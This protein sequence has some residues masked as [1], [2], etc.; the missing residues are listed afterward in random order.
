[1]TTGDA[2]NQH[3]LTDDQL[4]MLL[5]MTDDKLLNHIQAIVDPTTLQAIMDLTAATVGNTPHAAARDASHH[6]GTERS[7]DR[8]V[9]LITQRSALAR[10]CASASILAE[11]V[12]DH[13]PLP[14]ILAGATARLAQNLTRDLNGARVD[15][16]ALADTLHLA[17]DLA[18]ADN[19]AQILSHTLTY[20][21]IDNPESDYHV[22]A[23]ATSLARDLVH[24][25]DQI[26]HDACWGT[27]DVSAADLS[28]VLIHDVQAVTG[29]VWSDE[30][31]WPAGFADR[32]RT[33]SH[34][35]GPG[36]YQVRGGTERD[37]FE[38]SKR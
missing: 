18:H 19:L 23:R 7:Q 10:A 16:L 4:D 24:V 25:L 26:L 35:V 14:S 29:V 9:L 3:E 34:E 38:P 30:T 27:V 20:T 22:R 2:D 5:N 13:L 11:G 37:P 15:V 6:G 31:V 12:D 28:H 32:V 1:M 8:A 36:R 21:L 17:D 33:A